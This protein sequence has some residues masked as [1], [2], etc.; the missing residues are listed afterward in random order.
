MNKLEK[1]LAKP[2][3]VTICGEQYMLKPFTV[4]DLPLLTRL[5]SKEE[6][7]RTKALKEVIFKVLKQID[8]DATEELVDDVSVEFIEDIMNAVSKINNID[9]DDVKNKLLESKK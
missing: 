6:I 8:N 1:F 7:I 2:V 9:V 3:E 5:D 4:G